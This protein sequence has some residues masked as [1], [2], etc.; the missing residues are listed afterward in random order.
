MY[1]YYNPPNLRL[2]IMQRN[3][4]SACMMPLARILDIYIFCFIDARDY[5]CAFNRLRKT[6]IDNVPSDNV[7]SDNVPSDNVL[8]TRTE[9]VP[10]VFSVFR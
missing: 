1:M 7:P 4:L 9:E 2:F 10:H 6:C 3:Y 8:S 5:I